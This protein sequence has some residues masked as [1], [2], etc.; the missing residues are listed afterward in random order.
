MRGL[1]FSLPWPGTPPAGSH[2]RVV[3]RLTPAT[4][5]PQLAADATIATH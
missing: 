5:D 4:G 2:A 3:V 1:H